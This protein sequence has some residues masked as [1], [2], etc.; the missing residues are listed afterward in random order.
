MEF[1]VFL[2]V[3]IVVLLGYLTI[4]G[5]FMNI[6]LA[7]KDVKL[8]GDLVEEL[9]NEI[10]LAGLSNNGYQKA[11]NLTNKINNKDY[12]INIPSG[13]REI[14][15]ILD[16][17]HFTA[18]LA[19]EIEEA[20]PDINP[21]ETIYILKYNDKVY[22]SIFGE[23]NEE[24]LGEQT[25]GTPSQ[26]LDIPNNDG[27]VVECQL[28]NEIY[29]W[30]ILEFCGETRCSEESCGSPII[31]NPCLP[32]LNCDNYYGNQGCANPSWT[33]IGICFRRGGA[34]ICCRNPAGEIG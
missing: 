3:A 20:S 31:Y 22:I 27:C 24:I 13:S 7:N 14:A 19:T 28:N 33:V 2:S 12:T 6:T 17:N 23:C 21:G 25:C 8:A 18:Q 30:R 9:K 10:N 15:I 4:S 5:N 29:E 34:E 26:C 1:L 11:Y 32:P 16:G